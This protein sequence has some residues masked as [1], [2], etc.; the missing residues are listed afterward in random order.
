MYVCDRNIHL[1]LEFYHLWSVFEVR[2]ATIKIPF[3]GGCN[4]TDKEF[5][6]EIWG[7]ICASVHMPVIWF[8]SRTIV[9]HNVFEI[10]K[11][12]L[13]WDVI[14]EP[15]VLRMAWIVVFKSQAYYVF[16]YLAHMGGRG[17]GHRIKS[18]CDPI[19]IENFTA[20]SIK[21]PKTFAFP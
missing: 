7:S 16:K 14:I 19:T 1:K 18:W 13:I 8:E 5:R 11:H 21:M 2:F 9:Q 3:T 17:G 20:E 6:A 10:E 12:T 15:L 4:A